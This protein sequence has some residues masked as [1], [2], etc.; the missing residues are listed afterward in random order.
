VIV[1]LARATRERTGEQNWDKP[2][3]NALQATPTLL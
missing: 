2:Q 3:A 1:R